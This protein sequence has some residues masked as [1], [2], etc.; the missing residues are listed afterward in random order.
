MNLEGTAGSTRKGRESSGLSLSSHSRSRGGTPGLW[1]YSIAVTTQRCRISDSSRVFHESGTL[2]CW[3]LSQ[4]LNLNYHRALRQGR[5]SIS[6]ET[7]AC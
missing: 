2:K 4:S 3:S 7:L 5:K 1:L 6:G